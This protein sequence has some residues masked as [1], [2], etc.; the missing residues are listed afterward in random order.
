M[1]DNEK[2]ADVS[3]RAFMKNGA[4]VG[5]AV[6]AGLGAQGNRSQRR[7]DHVADVVIMGAGAAGLTAAVRARP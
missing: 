7:W 5:A 2:K 3:R 4:A 6:L 1:S